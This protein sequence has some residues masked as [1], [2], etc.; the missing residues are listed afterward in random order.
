MIKSLSSIIS[1]FN[2]KTVMEL[3]ILGLIL[4]IA[5]IFR[6]YKIRWGPYLDAFDPLYQYRVT[7]YIVDNGYSSFFDWHDSLSWWP[8]GRNVARNTFP[9]VPFS[10]AFI[11]LVLQMIGVNITVHTVCLFFPVLM[12]VLTCIAIF[13]LGKD[14]GGGSVGLL[15]AFFMAIN[16]AFI[17]RTALGFFDT[18]NIGIFG[19]VTVS[20]FF[21]RSIETEKKWSNRLMYILASSLTLGYVF[22]SWG[23]ARYILGLLTLY[24]LASVFYNLHNKNHLVSYSITIGLGYLFTLFIPRLGVKYLS[25]IE[26]ILVIFVIFFLLVFNYLKTKVDHKKL[27]LLMVGVVFISIVS[28]IGLESLGVVRPIASKFIR[29]LFPVAEFMPLTESVAEHHRSAWTGYF[30]N[31]GSLLVFGVL[32]VYL[33]LTNINDKRLYSALFF[34]TGAYFAGS[35]ARLALI[36]SIPV[37]LMAALGIKELL[38]PFIQISRQKTDDRRRRR[39]GVYIISREFALIFTILVF[40]VTIPIIWGT[41][42]ASIRPTSLASSNIPGTVR[43]KYPQ[44]WIQALSWMRDNLP[45]DAIVVSWWDYG[46]WIESMANRITLAD[47]ATT[48]MTQIAQIGRMLMLN[49]S[50]S[51]PIFNRYGATHIV[52]FQTFFNPDNPQQQWPFGDN[53]KWS[54]MVQIAGMNVSK[55]FDGQSYTDVFKESVLAR[56]MSLNPPRGFNI[57][58]WSENQF[59]LVYEIDYRTNQT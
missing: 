4:I 41:A 53:A 50:E 33:S 11:Y 24:I 19:M 21:L 17:G 45:E 3:S 55:F 42:E 14:L 26:N 57:V 37:C 40:A 22:S 18:E 9:G 35:M 59:V 20:L 25:S 23:A 28:L 46:Y 52:V 10:A 29:V 47:G 15:A 27:L 34:V 31:F 30:G 39:K 43:G 56:L 49:E 8:W 51:L 2:V 44:D 58:F 54:W 1:R 6:V 16:E 12:A 38:I 36:L 13:F 5:I 32:G 7:E 48:N